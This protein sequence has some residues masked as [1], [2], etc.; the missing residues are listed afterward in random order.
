MLVTRGVEG[1]GGGEGVEG[2]GNGHKQNEGNTTKQI[3]LSNYEQM[4]A[5]SITLTKV[6]LSLY[7]LVKNMA[8]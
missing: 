4:K 7:E 8:R 1:G 5:K 2:G 3:L 6:Q